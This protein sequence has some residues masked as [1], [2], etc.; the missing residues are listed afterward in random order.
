MQ[1]AIGNQAHPTIQELHNLIQVHCPAPN[2]NIDIAPV[3]DYVTRYDLWIKVAA[4]ENQV[5][6][7]HQA[8]CKWYLKLRE[9]DPQA[10]IYP[11][12]SRVCDKEGLLIENPTDIP[13]SLPL[14]KKFVRKLFLCTTGGAYHIQVLLGTTIN[15]AKIMET[16]R[17]WCKS[18]EQGM[19]HTDLQS[20][21]ETLCARWLLF[22][23]KEY[24]HEALSREIWNLTGVNIAL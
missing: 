15:L 19:W 16:I 21:E 11:W 12:T 8:F 6:L 5:E 22:S 9:A 1:E 23:A 3:K 17:W 14:L 2:N 20:A 10:L 18:T 7:F 24:N 13:T 4:G